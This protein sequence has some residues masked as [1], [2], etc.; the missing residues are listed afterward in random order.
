MKYYYTYLITNTKINKFYHGKHT[1][2]CH[3][4]KEIG[5]VYFSTS[6][7]KEF[8][9]DQKDNPQDYQYTIT[10]IYSTGKESSLNESEFHKIHN[11]KNN[12]QFYNRTNAGK[13]DNTGNT[14]YVTVKDKDGKCFSVS[15]DDERYLSGEFVGTFKDRSHSEKTK[16]VMSSIFIE[17]RLGIGNKNSQYGS[18]WIYSSELQQNKKISKGDFIPKGWVKGRKIK[19]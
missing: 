6:Y 8:L 19:F 2:R 14:G 11:V 3:P 9:Q 17:R 13:F 1:C 15:V 10:G 4:I 5:S 7:D 18:M 12:P 16:N